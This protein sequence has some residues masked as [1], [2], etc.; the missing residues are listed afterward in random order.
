MRQSTA[1]ETLNSE[2]SKQSSPTNTSGLRPR[3]AA[4][5][6][7]PADT[8]LKAERIVIPE[9]VAGSTAIADQRVRIIEVGPL[10]WEK[11]AMPRALVGQIVL[12]TKYAGMLAPGADGKLYRLVNDKDI[13][14]TVEE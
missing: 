11:E 2:Q 7:I 13:F 4:V 10:A 12:V 1:Y 8:T 14:C 3:G 9:S 5:L 6:V